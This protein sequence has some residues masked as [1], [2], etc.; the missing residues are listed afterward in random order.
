MVRQLEHKEYDNK[1]K[2]HNI[3]VVLDNL[4]Y[5]KNIGSVFRLS[6]A[7]CVSKVII[8]DDKN[9]LEASKAK[10]NYKK[11]DK[12]ARNCMNYVDY[13]IMTTDD[14]LKLANKDNLNLTALEITNK[15]KAINAIN[16]K[17][18]QNLTLIIGNERSGVS[19]KLLNICK[20]SVH[21][22]MYGVNSSLNVATALSIALYKITNDLN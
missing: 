10:T 9:L 14:F 17:S 19:N 16:F 15:S 7:F 11:I 12:T 6:D 18:E 2:K 4:S 8:L 13:K 1:Y 22:N 3:T 21:I 5:L 20:T